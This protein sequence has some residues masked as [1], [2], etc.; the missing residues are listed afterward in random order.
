M[1]PVGEILAEFLTTE[2]KETHP[3]LPLWNTINANDPEIKRYN[4][5]TTVKPGEA[6]FGTGRPY[7]N[8]KTGTIFDV[9]FASK[10]PANYKETRAILQ[11][12]KAYPASI[13]P[14]LQAGYSGI[15]LIDFPAGVPGMTDK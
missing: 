15:C 9:I 2:K 1:E 8:I 13:E 10:D 3:M 12:V 11:T 4:L 14:V 7:M 5:S 6:Y